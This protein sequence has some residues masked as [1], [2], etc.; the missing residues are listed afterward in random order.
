MKHRGLLALIAVNLL[1][2]LA[3]A[4][5]YPHEMVG[6]GPVDA[7]H[8]EL[9]TDCFKCHAPWRGA[10][11]ERCK[12][13]HH[14]Q[15]IGLRTT[16]G[17]PV[18][19][20]RLKTSFHQSLQEEDCA[21][22]HFLHRPP[23]LV[24]RVHRPFSHDVFSARDRERCASCHVAPRD[25]MHQHIDRQCGECHRLERW[26]PAA[27]DHDDY[28]KLDKHHNKKCATCHS[29]KDYG[30]YTCYGCHEH[31]PKKI[32]AEHLEEGI[33]DVEDCAA[34][35]PDSRESHASRKP[36]ARPQRSRPESAGPG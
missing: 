33:E 23:A 16:Q 17:Q 31:K 25:R 6:P 36:R 28:F 21:R 1:V 26:S 10:A 29:G 24:R 3:F 5:E 30:D 35:H 15:D 32:R 13:C 4:I 9:E 7:A 12:D 11:S 19:H 8:A 18:A 22:C 14:P 20:E 34:C 2:L 27:F